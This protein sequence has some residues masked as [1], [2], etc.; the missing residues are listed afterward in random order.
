MRDLMRLIFGVGLLLPHYLALRRFT[1]GA[2]ANAAAIRFASSL[3]SLGPTFVKLGQILSTRPDVIPKAYVA[4]LAS[5]QEHGPRSRVWWLPPRSEG[6][7]ASP[8]KSC[9]PRSSTS[10]SRNRNDDRQ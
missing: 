8:S 4:A 10:R 6:N 3:V 9:S 2:A 1:A 7:S 5:L